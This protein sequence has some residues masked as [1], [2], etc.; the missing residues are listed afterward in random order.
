MYSIYNMMCHMTLFMV[1]EES[2]NIVGASGNYSCLL[3]VYCNKLIGEKAYYFINMQKGKAI[4]WGKP[5]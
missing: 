3:K 1:D 5:L 4:S 2:M